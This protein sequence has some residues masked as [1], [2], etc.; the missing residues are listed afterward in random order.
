VLLLVQM[1]SSSIPTGSILALNV[2]LSPLFIEKSFVSL[3]L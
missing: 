3:F 1:I 2:I